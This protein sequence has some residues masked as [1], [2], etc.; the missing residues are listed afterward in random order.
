MKHRFLSIAASVF[1]ASSFF[2]AGCKE[3]TIIKANAVPGIDGINVIGVSLPINCTTILDD[4][5]VTSERISGFRVTGG[6]GKINDKFFGRTNL[7]LY[8]QVAPNLANFSL[9]AGYML[10]SAVLVLPYTPMAWGDTTGDVTQSYSVYEVTDTMNITSTYY[11]RTQ[12]S[13][14]ALPVSKAPVVV[15]IKKGKTDSVVV[16]HNP[17]KRPPHLRIPLSESFRDR[18]LTEAKLSGSNADFISRIKGLCVRA[19]D[20]VS[21]SNDRLLPYFFLEGTEDYYRASVMFYYRDPAVKGGDST[22][23]SSFS[24]VTTDCAHYTR[25]SRNYTGSLAANYINKPVDSIL[26][27]QNQPGASIDIK[28]PG[29][30]NIPPAVINKAELVF[31]LIKL[32]NDPEAI[33]NDVYRMPEPTRIL[34]Y[35]VDATG[36]VT[37][38]LDLGGNMAS[39][40][41]LDFIDGNRRILTV[42]GMNIVQYVINIPREVQRA[43]VNK[44]DTLHLRITGT[45]SFPGAYRAVFGGNRADY[46]V[47]FN[48]TYSK[49]K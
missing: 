6:A 41:S 17:I 49:L 45:T 47:G 14:G 44:T 40:A 38:V 8:F 46:K 30:K 35:V 36:A 4:S 13:T 31:T 42:N 20:T 7:G 1:A 24:F 39:E 5:L 23:T 16:G 29:L 2:F 26:L 18:M 32:A 12:K 19:T 27:L 34:P 9:P 21:A 15:D 43:V 10:D 33:S 28:I 37:E 48:I 3:D 11:S 22:L 25:V